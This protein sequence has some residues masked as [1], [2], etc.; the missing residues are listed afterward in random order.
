[1]IQ[2]CSFDVGMDHEDGLRKE[3][4]YSVTTQYEKVN[5]FRHQSKDRRLPRYVS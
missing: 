1:M 4:A 5:S 2:T 3:S